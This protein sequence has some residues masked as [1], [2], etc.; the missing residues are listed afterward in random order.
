MLVMK[1]DKELSTKECIEYA[2]Q[3]SAHLGEKVVILDNKVKDFYRLDEEKL[4]YPVMPV[5][6]IYP[7]DDYWHYTTCSDT[8]CGTLTSDN[9]SWTYNKTSL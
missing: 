8:S 9:L 3:L 6:P 5:Y 1:I 2:E 4:I 7:R